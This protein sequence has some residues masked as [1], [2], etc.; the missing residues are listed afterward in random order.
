MKDLI[1]NVFAKTGSI[2]SYLLYKEMDKD[3]VREKNERDYKTSAHP[4]S[5][6]ALHQL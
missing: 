1:W 4:G 6:T 5:G 3:G 2:T